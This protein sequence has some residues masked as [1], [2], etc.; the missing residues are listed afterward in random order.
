MQFYFLHTTL[1]ENMMWLPSSPFLNEKIIK[2]L[3][4]F[5]LESSGTWF[6]LMPKHKKQKKTLKKNL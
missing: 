5:S 3:G 6:S 4:F 1:V 2:W